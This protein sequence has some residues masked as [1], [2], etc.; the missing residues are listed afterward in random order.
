VGWDLGQVNTPPTQ[1][2]LTFSPAIPGAPTSVAFDGVHAMSIFVPGA[3]PNANY[4]VTVTPRTGGVTGDPAVILISQ[5]APL[6]CPSSGVPISLPFVGS[7]E[8]GPQIPNAPCRRS[9]PPQRG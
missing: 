4:K 9:L 2:D 5:K 7:R 6:V 3:D 1:W 8:G